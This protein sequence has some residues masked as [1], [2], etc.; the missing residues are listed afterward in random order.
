MHGLPIVLGPVDIYAGQL[1]QVVHF[2]S[3]PVAQLPAALVSWIGGCTVSSALPLA[4]PR[5]STSPNTLRCVKGGG[6]VDHVGEST[7]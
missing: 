1:R 3:A 7:A 6:K 4:T 5:S 2:C